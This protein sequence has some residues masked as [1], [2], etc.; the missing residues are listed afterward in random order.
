M[1]FKIVNFA[2]EQSIPVFREN[3]N[4]LWVNYGSDN[5]YPQYLLNVFNNFSNKHKTIINRKVEMSTGAGFVDPVTNELKSFYENKW[6]SMPMNE[7]VKKIDYDLEIYGGFS[8]F[9]KWNAEGTKVVA[10]DYA[11][12]H[13]IRCGVEDNDYYI[14][15]NWK[16]Y[17]QNKPIRYQGYDPMKAMKD[18]VQIY[19]F[20]NDGPGTEWYPIPQYSSTLN[21]IEL[22]WEI[23]NFHLSSIRNGF[24]PSFVLNF[25]SGVPTE[26][27]MA[28][29]Q[30]A[31]EK[32]F[33]GSENAGKFILT[34]S[35]GQDGKPELI[36]INLND[37]D[38]RFILLQK[39]IETEIF[40][41]HG[42]VSPMLFGI[43]TEGQLGGR[44]ELLEAQALF[45]SI[46]I[47]NRQK[48][49]EGQ[50][51]KLAKMCGVV[52]E[53]KLNKYRLDFSN[54]VE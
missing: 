43:R 13:K 33:T 49:I 40:I 44:N 32:E 6:G 25:A 30:K 53:V 45:Q 2:K 10:L 27:V 17:Y 23:S 26:E 34:Y 37:S 29:A 12:Y 21:W 11:P 22:D 48:L 20:I 4:G 7:I 42:V 50:L 16:Q 39:Q 15:K 36:P 52:E 9:V 3:K 46:Y 24:M 18:P 14:C 5:L 47:D 19:Y 54:I 1:N 35:E 51:N 31:F 41:G 8:L 38:K 28:D